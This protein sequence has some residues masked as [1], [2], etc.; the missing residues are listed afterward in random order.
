MLLPCA[1]GGLPAERSTSTL[2]V[3]VLAGIPAYTKIYI[4]ICMYIYIYVYVYNIKMDVYIYAYTLQISTAMQS[5]IHVYAC[6]HIYL[7]TCLAARG[8]FRSRRRGDGQ[9]KRIVGFPE[10]ITSSFS[11]RPS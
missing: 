4:Y 8:E 2:R 7:C 9:S 6:V 11:C 10:H 3:W 1:L 5:C